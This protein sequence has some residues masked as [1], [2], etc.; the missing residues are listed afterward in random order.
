[1]YD[2]PSKDDKDRDRQKTAGFLQFFQNK[3]P[4]LFPNFPVH[5]R[6]LYCHRFQY[7][8]LVTTVSL[9]KTAELIEV[10]F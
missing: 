10:P 9:A 6:D 1:M 5:F 7:G 4:R 2:A 8:V 3:I